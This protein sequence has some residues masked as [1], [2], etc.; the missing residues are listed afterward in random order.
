MLSFSRSTLVEDYL[1]YWEGDPAFDKDADNFK[2]EYDKAVESGDWSNVPRAEGGAEPTG[3]KLR[4]LRG[5][6]RRY[7]QDIADRGGMQALREVAALALTGLKDAP[8]PRNDGKDYHLS[9]ETNEVGM[10]VVSE[11]DMD[12]LD[13]FDGGTLVNSI[14][15]RAAKEMRPSKN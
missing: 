5:K 6:A 4:H 13:R 15:S 11:K 1:H 3:F 7:V 10:K 14:G 2:A 9:F 12:E 8:D